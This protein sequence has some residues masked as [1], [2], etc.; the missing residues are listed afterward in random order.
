MSEIVCQEGVWTPPSSRH[1]FSYRLWQPPACQAL[2]VIVHGFAEHG[3]RYDRFA[4]ALAAQGICV[5]APDLWGHGLTDGQRGDAETF[6]DYIE[7]ILAMTRERFLLA[8]RQRRY[9][10]FGHSFGGLVAIRWLLDDADDVHH[11]VIQSPL[12]EVGFPVPQWK[13]TLARVFARWWPTLSFSL[14]VDV[15]NLSHDPRV[16]RTYVTDPLIH[17][18][19]SARTYCAMLEA[20]DDVMRRA[21]TQRV[22][23]LALCGT[24]DHVIL[25]DAVERWFERL[26]CEKRLEL[27]PGAYHE[28]HHEPAIRDQV[29][30]LVA[31]WVLRG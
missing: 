3:G 18:C 6:T 25:V 10:L 22:P 12:L 13:T 30:Q 1:H 8:A 29:V 26:T 17:N 19:M 21:P 2:L 9:S 31:E 5:A 27:F 7:P 4:R 24:E 11:A 20:R 28:L 14:D 23:T 15:K 16:W